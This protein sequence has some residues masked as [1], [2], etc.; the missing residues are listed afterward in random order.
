MFTMLNTESIIQ[1]ITQLMEQYEFNASS[2]AEKIGVQRSSISH[3]LSGRNKPSLEFLV[4]IEKNFPEVT[5]EWLLKGQENPEPISL[6]S[7]APTQIA[8][9]NQAIRMEEN[10]SSSEKIDAPIKIV[11][12]YADGSFESFFK[13]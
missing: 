5:F 4:K 11:H 10:I 2:F 7:P 9:R 1:R 13:R 3:I 12:Y 6:P 8:S